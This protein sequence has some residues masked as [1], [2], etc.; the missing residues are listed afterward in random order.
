[1]NR[2]RIPCFSPFKLLRSTAMSIAV[3][4]LSLILATVGCTVSQEEAKEAEADIADMP[5]EVQVSAS[6]LADEYESNELAANQQ[7]DGKV[8]EVTGAIEAVSGGKDGAALYVDL[9]TGDF[10]FVSVRCHFSNDRLDEL[11]ALSKG[12]EVILRGLGDEGED[13]DPFTID[14]IGCSVIK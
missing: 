3:L 9:E 5:I 11:T 4:S 2:S 8:L 6:T 1:M 10:S 12:D 14:V 13:R 7:Y